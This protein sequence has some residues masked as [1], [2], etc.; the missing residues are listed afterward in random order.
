MWYDYE[1]AALLGY[2]GQPQCPVLVAE[3]YSTGGEFPKPA[4]MAE[5]GVDRRFFPTGA[6]GFTQSRRAGEPARWRG[7]KIHR[8][9]CPVFCVTDTYRSSAPV[10]PS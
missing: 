8:T 2:V 1:R 10:H 9:N 4:S 3:G 5:D 6:V 7:T